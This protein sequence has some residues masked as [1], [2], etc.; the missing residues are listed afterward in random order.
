MY[1]A[2]AELNQ[3]Q[4]KSAIVSCIIVRPSFMIYALLRCFA[5]WSSLISRCENCASTG[6]SPIQ[7]TLAPFIDGYQAGLYSGDAEATCYNLSSRSIHLFSA[8]RPLAGLQHELES[9]ASVCA[10]L[11]QS[12]AQNSKCTSLLVAIRGVLCA[13][14]FLNSSDKS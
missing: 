6:N 8:G 14:F 4:S 11:N 1:R 3:E 12:P 9:F 10:Q 7:Q 5:S 13:H 2:L